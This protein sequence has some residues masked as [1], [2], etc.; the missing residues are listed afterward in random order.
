MRRHRF[1]VRA[2]LVITITFALLGG[3]WAGWQWVRDRVLVPRV[4]D[5][6]REY[7]ERQRGWR[8]TYQSISSNLFSHLSLGDL[9]LELA[10][11]PHGGRQLPPVVLAIDRLQIR[12]SPWGIWRKQI[13]H[14][15]IQGARVILGATTIRLNVAQTGDHIEITCPM[16]PI[17][18]EHLLNHYG[19]PHEFIAE[20]LLELEGRWAFKSYRSD[21]FR[22]SARGTDLRIRWDPALDARVNLALIVSGAGTTPTL[23]GTVDV[24]DALWSGTG[25]HP[26]GVALGKDEPLLLRW[27]DRFPGTI[28]VDLKGTE[29]A[30]QT[31]HLH[32]KLK[33]ALQLQKGSGQPTRLVGA[34]HTSSGTYTVKRRTFRIERGTIRFAERTQTS[35]ELHAVLHTRVK[36][37]RIRVAV[38]GTLGDS[39]LHISSRPELPREDILALLVFGRRV[40]SLAPEERQA[41]SGRDEATQTLDFLLLGRAELLAARWLG[42]DEINVN[43]A[44]RATTPAQTGGSPI[45]SVELG[46]YVIPDR[47]FGSYKLQPP[48]TPLEAP[49]HTVG[50]AL[51]LTDRLSVEGTVTAT[52]QEPQQSTTESTQTSS[53]PARRVEAE[54]A[55]IRFRWKF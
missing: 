44:P 52:V 7:V 28:Q 26:V 11:P 49:R 40:A 18:V 15:N 32:A 1:G 12:Y 25:V 8:L 24:T 5:V 37:Y 42:L 33:A 10:L 17:P 3:G 16:Q 14:W 34:L 39:Q 6:L 54:E 45:E 48:Q 4:G 53:P 2:A 19:V 9:R 47:V 43:F 30:V 50:A 22:F 21:Q 27:A 41:L 51:Q 20:G 31:D 29:L 35:P 46:K 23:H 55:L 38:S 13:D 36:R